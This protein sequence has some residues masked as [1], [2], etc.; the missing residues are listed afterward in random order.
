MVFDSDAGAGA[1]FAAH[2]L[3]EVAICYT[4]DPTSADPGKHDL[5]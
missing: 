4:G 1:H 5:A 3:C 2:K